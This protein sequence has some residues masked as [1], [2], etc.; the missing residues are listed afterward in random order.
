MLLLEDR[1]FYVYVYL[2]PTKPGEYKY[3]DYTF[4]YCPFYVGKGSDNR[5]Y[6]HMH[7]SNLK[8]NSCK[9]NKIKKLKKAGFEPIVFKYMEHL[10][11][12]ESF[13]FEIDMIK[14][15][16]R[17]DEELGNLTNLTYGGDGATGTIPSQD[18]RRKISESHKGE[19]NHFFGKHHS[20]ESKRKIS[21]NKKGQKPW[22]TGRY[23]TKESRQKMSEA[24]R[25]KNH[26]NYGTHRSDETRR[27][28][29]LANKGDKHPQYGKPRSEETKQKIRMNSTT[30]K[31]TIIEGK[32]YYSIREAHRIIN[33]PEA[34]IKY[35]L[36]SK[37]FPN[38]KYA[39]A[40]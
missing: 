6:D 32:Y 35:R 29:S 38:Y 21:K 25:G 18:T 34:T 10:T 7:P 30:C 14:T 37:N 17:R 4:E 24:Q 5:L 1:R 19:K 3:G 33:M 27:K 15:I 23:H 13:D 31:P 26:P 12:Q 36:K 22:M 9:N 40:A 2:D 20:N 28:I 16:G 39:S 11:E 8:N